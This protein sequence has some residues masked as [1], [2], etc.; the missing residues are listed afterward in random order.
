MNWHLYRELSV[1][2][3]YAIFIFSAVNYMCQ[4]ILFQRHSFHFFKLELFYWINISI[5]K[6]FSFFFC[7]KVFSHDAFPNYPFNLLE[8]IPHDGEWICWRRRRRWKIVFCT[9]FILLSL[10]L[11]L[12]Y[13]VVYVCKFSYF[14]TEINWCWEDILNLVSL[15]MRI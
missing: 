1:D 11:C 9:F 14:I 12:R 4:L 3:V 6:I 2:D 5:I 7:T 8:Y 13:S 10:S 15:F